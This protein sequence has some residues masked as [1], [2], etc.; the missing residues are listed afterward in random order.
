[1]KFNNI[2]YSQDK[3]LAT[4]TL[5]RPD[6]LNSFT[7]DM[8]EELRTA[9]AEVA[10]NDGVRALLLTGAG[11]GFCAGQD[12]NDRA[13]SPESGPPDLGEAIKNN[14]NPLIRTITGLPKPVI[15]AMN[16]VA[17]GAGA[18]VAL[19]C[20]IVLAARSASF[21]QVFSKIGLIPDSG[22]S[23]HLPRAL[24]LPRAKALAMTGDKLPAETAQEWGMIWRCV[25]NDN[26]M[27]EATKLGHE[28]SNRPTLALAAIKEIFSSSSTMPLHEHLEVERS[29]MHRLG[30]TDDYAEGVQAFLEK[31]A[32]EFKGK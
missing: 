23:W 18:S 20:D 21:I 22:G 13:T 5:N 9:L 30:Q 15:C 7:A 29:T 16:G 24:T 17:A 27:E 28:L 26:L 2:I 19:A 1:M 32:P 11:R 25:D 31:R 8:H 3:Q 12:L 4:I 14:W 6:S 10:S